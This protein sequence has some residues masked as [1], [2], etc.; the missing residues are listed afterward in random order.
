MEI[1]RFG[2][3]F[4]WYRIVPREIIFYFK[5]LYFKLLDSFSVPI[6]L[7]TFFAPWKRDEIYV[8]NAPLNIRFYVWAMNQISRLIGVILRS[9]VLVGFVIALALWGIGLVSVLCFWLFYPVIVLVLLVAGVFY[10]I[11]GIY[12]P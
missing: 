12:G 4:F 3:W 1:S 9:S 5:I 10:L 8:K 7:K 2:F 11:K 6:I